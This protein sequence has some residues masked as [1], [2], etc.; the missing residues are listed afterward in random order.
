MFRSKLPYS[1]AI[2]FSRNR[3]SAGHRYQT[4]VSFDLNR[5]GGGTLAFGLVSYSSSS[6]NGGF[7]VS[8]LEYLA[9]PV[10]KTKLR[11]DNEK[12][13]LVSD[14]LKVA[15]PIR[16]GIPILLM[17]SARILEGS[18]L[19]QKSTSQADDLGNSIGNK[20]F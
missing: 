20:P 2:R 1:A 19:A 16:N 12:Q 8:S 3:Q 17:Q 10:S 11:F 6:S 9:C 14:E 13:E 7:N 18:P 5:F 15:F 4:L